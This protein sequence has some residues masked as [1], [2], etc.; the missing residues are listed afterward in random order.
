LVLLLSVQSVKELFL[1]IPPTPLKG[2]SG[3][4]GNAF[5]NYHQEKN[6]KNSRQSRNFSE[7][8]T[9]VKEGWPKIA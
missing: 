4:K 5:H 8:L 7:D 1:F 9:K 6:T 2:E 3:C